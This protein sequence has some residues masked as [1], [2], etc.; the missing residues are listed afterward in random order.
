MLNKEM[1][2]IHTEKLDQVGWE[3]LRQCTRSP[4]TKYI[5]YIQPIKVV[6]ELILVRIIEEQN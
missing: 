6:G 2:D 3:P 4:E 1:T 5:Y